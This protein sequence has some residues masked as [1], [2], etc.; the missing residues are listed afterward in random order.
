MLEIIF[1]IFLIVF[2]IASIVSMIYLIRFA[3]SPES[4]DER[5]SDI[6]QRMS[7]FAL[8]IFMIGSIILI[9]L[10]GFH[11]VTAE[12]FVKIFR[13]FFSSIFILEAIFLYKLRKM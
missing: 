5:G 4:K 12:Q 13:Y 2:L 3:R 8:V 7:S 10:E 11:V 6:W 1:M 9:N